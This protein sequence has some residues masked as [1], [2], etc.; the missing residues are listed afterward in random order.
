MPSNVTRFLNF[1]RGQDGVLPPRLAAQYLGITQQ[2]LTQ[3][4]AKRKVEAIRHAGRAYYGCRS[5][6]FF[7]EYRTAVDRASKVFNIDVTP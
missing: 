7:K 5:L 6:R 4:L 1:Q 2:A 3:A